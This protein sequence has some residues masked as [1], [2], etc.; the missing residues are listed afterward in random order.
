MT[1]FVWPNGVRMSA[2]DWKH[3]SNSQFSDTLFGGAIQTASFPG[4]KLACTVYVSGATGTERARLRALA[5]RLRGRGNRIWLQ[6]LS[7]TG[8]R[9]GSF[10]A[11]ELFSNVDFLST[12]GWTAGSDAALSVSDQTLR[13]KRI[14][15]S[16]AS[17]GNAYAQS[18]AIT[19]IAHI[20]YVG[21]FVFG[22]T[23]GT[24]N[25][26]TTWQGTPTYAQQISKSS[27]TPGY[28]WSEGVWSVTSAGFYG[29]NPG[30][31]VSLAGDYYD[32]LFAS[33]SRNIAVDGRAN[34]LIRSDEFDNTSAWG[35]AA[36][37]GLSSVSADAALAP[38]GTTTA[39]SL[40]ENSSAGIHI[41]DQNITV[42]SASADFM[43]CVALKAGS[44]TWAQVTLA[45]A[46][47]SA[48]TYFNLSTGATGSGPTGAGWA[49]QRAFVVSLGNGWYYC[50]VVIRKTSADTTV[51][52]AIYL[53]TGDGVNSYTGN[54]TGNIL[55]WRATCAPTPFPGRLVQ[56]T[57]TATGTSGTSQQGSTVYVK[58]LP[59]STAGLLK[60][61]DQ[62]EIDK[63]LKF[64][65]AD[66]D[67][68]AGGMG[69][70]QLDTPLA[71]G[72]TD[73]APVI[74]EKPMAKFILT[75][76][77]EYPT[78]PGVVSDFKFSFVQDLAA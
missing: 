74:V 41:R 6:D 7:I 67:S 56:T 22:D 33:A 16:S 40:I 60:A 66:L 4:D 15:N 30:G 26:S 54:G 21:R 24:A 12:A 51:S 68:D 72:V 65:V 59:V 44:R 61:G 57:T 45:S 78:A 2:V 13:V 11:S 46:S 42:S 8:R 36:S 71:R 73:C 69:L 25:F 77:V 63:Q 35:T 50:C 52:P 1:E 47:G 29:D 39:D 53:A 28:W 19:T 62:V 34:L 32:V 17:T 43:F 75:D 70:L 48:G 27:G 23:S 14:A 10:P 38:D 9:R 18:P 5:G 37:D 49:N 3:Q 58:A 64:L 55:A 20:P 31:I 76:D